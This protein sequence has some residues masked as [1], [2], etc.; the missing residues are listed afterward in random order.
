MAFEFKDIFFS[1]LD[2]KKKTVSTGTRQ[3]TTY[4]N[5]L[6]ESYSQTLIIPELVSTPRG[7]YKLT[8]IGQYSFFN[9]TNLRSIYIPASVKIIRN[10]GVS[11]LHQLEN[12][13]FAKDSRL[14]VIE[15]VGLYDMYSIRE[16]VFPGNCLK[17]INR[18]A[19]SYAFVL[20]RLVLPAS[21]QSMG[22]A[23]IAGLRSLDDLYYCGSVVINEEVFFKDHEDTDITNSTLR[24][25]VSPNYQSDTFG[26]RQVTDRNLQ[27]YCQTVPFVCSDVDY[28]ICS[29]H[30]HP[31]LSYL[32]VMIYLL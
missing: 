15:E 10:Y 4:P 18:Y 25:H 29:I 23:S 24:I 16:L 17:T 19:I 22:K 3:Q 1:F 9:A 12:I 11:Y 5:A 2:H 6:K 20:N 13:T 8:E 26:G 21:I 30:F 28:S 7:V 27:D 32:F 31:S 14:S